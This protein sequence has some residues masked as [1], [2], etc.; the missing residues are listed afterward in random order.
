LINSVTGTQSR[1]QFITG[2]KWQE[3][4]VE[5]LAPNILGQVGEVCLMNGFSTNKIA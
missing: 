1:V 5:K 3:E 2:F 4:M